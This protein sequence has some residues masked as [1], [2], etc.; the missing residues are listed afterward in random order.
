MDWKGVGSVGGG[1]GTGKG[2]GK[3]MRMRLSKLPFSN[4]RYY[5]PFSFPRKCHETSLKWL[6][7]FTSVVYPTR[8]EHCHRQQN[9]YCP[10]VFLVEVTI[11]YGLQLKLWPRPELVKLMLHLQ[12]CVEFPEN[13]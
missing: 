10:Q 4:L 8:Q 1:V 5:L 11:N 3:S 6:G 7:L 13:S 9:R 2:I 12:H